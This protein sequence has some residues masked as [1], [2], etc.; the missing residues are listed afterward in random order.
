MNVLEI[1]RAAIPNADESL[2][3]AIVWGRTP[4]PFAPVTAKSLYHAAYRWQRASKHG[5]QLCEFC[6]RPAA[7]KWLCERCDAALSRT[8]GSPEGRT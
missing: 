2:A 4:Y 7:G 6:D 8:D 5:V 1:V 3:E